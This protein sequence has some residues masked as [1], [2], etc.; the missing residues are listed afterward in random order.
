MPGTTDLLKDLVEHYQLHIITNGFEEIQAIK[1]ETS[2]ITPYFSTVICSDR[3]G[4]KK[5]DARIFA[6]ALKKARG[7]SEDALMIGNDLYADMS[8]ARNAGWDHVHFAAECE[9]DA[10]ATYTVRSMKDLRAILLR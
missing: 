8:G 4:A 6:Y 9:P 1:I 2:G 7:R 5:P 10:E 3:A